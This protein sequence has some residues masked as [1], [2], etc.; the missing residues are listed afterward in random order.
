MALTLT[1]A[2]ST[3]RSELRDPSGLAWPDE[4]LTEALRDAL[5]LYA[6][7][8][9]RVT[10]Q[11]YTL[12]GLAGKDEVTLPSAWAIREALA[13][14]A[15]WDTTR[16]ASA[17]MTPRPFQLTAPPNGLVLMDGHRFAD[18][19]VVR[20]LYTT[21]HTLNGLDG[22]GATTVPASHERG[23]LLVAQAQAAVSRQRQVAEAENVT[24]AARL[25]VEGWARQQQREA[26]AWLASTRQSESAYVTWG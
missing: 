20:V 13:F 25:R 15:P 2:I 3:L 18:P 14:W 22:A 17:Q 21:D 24:S 6:E 23:L 8:A 26:R 5:A 19:E 9:P 12:T 11:V 10:S 1:T 7:A 4:I 16:P